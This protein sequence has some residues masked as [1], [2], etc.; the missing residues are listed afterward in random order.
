[1]ATEFGFTLPVEVR[2][3]APFRGVGPELGSF[4]DNILLIAMERT[5][6]PKP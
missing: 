1:M 3:S 5:A 2:R 6:L 4:E